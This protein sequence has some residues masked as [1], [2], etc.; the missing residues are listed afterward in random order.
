MFRLIAA[1]FLAKEFY[2]ICLNHVAMLR[3]HRHLRGFVKLS[4]VGCLLRQS[5]AAIDIP[6]NLA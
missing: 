5:I 3:S 1:I 4:L 2:I 6:P